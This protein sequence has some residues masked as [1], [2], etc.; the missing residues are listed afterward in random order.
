MLEMFNGVFVHRFRCVSVAVRVV[1][2]DMM[3]QWIQQYPTVY[4]QNT[5]AALVAAVADPTCGHLSRTSVTRRY[6]KY[7]GWLLSDSEHSVCF[8]IPLSLFAAHC[9]A[10][11]LQVRVRALKGLESLYEVAN[12][13]ALDGFTK[14]FRARIA[15]VCVGQLGAC[16][17][18][19]FPF[20]VDFRS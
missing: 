6:L 7:M 3:A 18:H 13:E 11:Q 14:R 10:R 9:R 5:Y 20:F 19:V 16:V 12:V 8:C 2:V 4:M 1:M 15:R 17:G